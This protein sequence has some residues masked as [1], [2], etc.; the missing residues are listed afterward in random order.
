MKRKMVFIGTLLW[1]L[2]VATQ[3][4]GE[5]KV[6]PAGVTFPDATT[7]TTAAKSTLNDV[8]QPTWH[9]ILPVENR[10]ILVMNNE[11]VL[12]KETGLVWRR[13]PWSTSTSWTTAL[14]DCYM[15]FT[16]DRYG[17]RMPTIE[18]LLSLFLPSDLGTPY[19][20]VGHPFQGTLTGKFWS[21]TS[22]DSS[23]EKVWVINIGVQ[24]MFAEP[25]VN[26]NKVWQVR[27]VYGKDGIR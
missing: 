6:T 25:I 17:W 26:V 18:E 20:P 13:T 16:G 15:S 9:Q 27:G 12:D 4:N 23:P 22:V 11:A 7:Q 21:T 3:S 14:R 2:I 1:L 5:M 10:F 24:P 19:L 8:C